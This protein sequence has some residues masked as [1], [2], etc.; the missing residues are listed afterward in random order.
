M[1]N[2]SLI[3]EHVNHFLA[4]LMKLVLHTRPPSSAHQQTKQTDLYIR[5]YSHLV[6]LTLPY[7]YLPLFVAII[8]VRLP[9]NVVVM[10]VPGS[11]RQR[12]S[13]VDSDRALTIA[14]Q[15]SNCFV[16]IMKFTT[17]WIYNSNVIN[18]KVTL[19]ISSTVMISRLNHWT[20]IN[21]FKYA[22]ITIRIANLRI[23]NWIC[24]S[25]QRWW[26][27][28]LGQRTHWHIFGYCLRPRA[29]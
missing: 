24:K 12:T 13:I 22:F 14:L 5:E 26:T 29:N 7:L 10:V 9:V 23:I 27:R 6:Q 25:Y 15:Y 4:I 16:H 21:W 1:R 11:R 19:S 8:M 2:C 17:C 18:A 20:D 28:N 3:E